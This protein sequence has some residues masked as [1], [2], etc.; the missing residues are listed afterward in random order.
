M[1]EQKALFTM[2]ITIANVAIILIH[3]TDSLSE[4]FFDLIII[5][6]RILVLIM[7]IMQQ[8]GLTFCPDKSLIPT[9]GFGIAMDQ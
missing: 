4:H 9:H 7:G 3:T 5:Q 2:G 8:H 1:H 6:I